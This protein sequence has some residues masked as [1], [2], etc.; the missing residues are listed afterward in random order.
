MGVCR[1]VIEWS[2]ENSRE[3]AKNIKMK[4]GVCGR[5][6]RRGESGGA[7]TATKHRNAP[8]K[9]PVSQMRELVEADT[10]TTK[11]QELPA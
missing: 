7:A 10:P 2:G 4:R 1:E 8:S 9:Y 3:S 11:V 6:N 5:G